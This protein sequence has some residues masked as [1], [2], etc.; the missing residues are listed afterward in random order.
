MYVLDDRYSTAVAFV[1]GYNIALDGE[2]LSGFQDW[3]SNRILGSSC[4]VHW[5]YVVASIRVPGILDD[6]VGIDRI[7]ADIEVNLID[8]MIDLIEM[9]LG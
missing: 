9:F 2:P 1:E 6:K 3:V 4:P 8:D 5:S 7:P